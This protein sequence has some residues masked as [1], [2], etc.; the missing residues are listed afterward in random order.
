MGSSERGR[1]LEYSRDRGFM[2][3]VFG[4]LLECFDWH[5]EFW[6]LGFRRYV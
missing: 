2:F 6:V 4:G 3:I 5:K 1:V